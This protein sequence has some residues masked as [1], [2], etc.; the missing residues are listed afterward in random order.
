[1]ARRPPVGTDTNVYI[2]NYVVT[3]TNICICIYVRTDKNIYICIYVGT[4]T[5]I[6][7]ILRKLTLRHA[8]PV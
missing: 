7:R 2:S 1:M 4:D 5:N 8:F 3:D 6:H